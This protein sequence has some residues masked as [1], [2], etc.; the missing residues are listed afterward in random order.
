M[1]GYSTNPTVQHQ[2][3]LS[4]QVPVQPQIQA[5]LAQSNDLQDPRARPTN[6]AN[7][8]KIPPSQPFTNQNPI[9]HP[10]NAIQ[11]N[12][13]FEP[14]GILKPDRQVWGS[15]PLQQAIHGNA[16]F[17]QKSEIDPVSP[18]IS[19]SPPSHQNIIKNISPK[20]RGVKE[21]VTPNKSEEL[22][23]L[24]VP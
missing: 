3:T 10:V 5:P 11:S 12:Y 14:P 19:I 20:K 22:I 15:N 21:L 13:P 17:T 9:Q 24:D 1:N 7:L 23:S 18:N 6:V 8:S 2:Q 4:T 16:S